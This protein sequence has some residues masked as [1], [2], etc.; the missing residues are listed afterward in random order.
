LLKQISPSSTAA[1]QDSA[2]SDPRQWLQNWAD[3]MRGRDP[4]AQASFYADTVDAYSGR[5]NVSNE[6]I[7]ANKR[8]GILNRRGLW[9]VRFDDISLHRQGDDDVSVNLVK[10][11][12][13]QVGPAQITEKFVRSRL[14]LR[15]IDGQWKIVSEQDL[16]LA[17]SP[18]ESDLP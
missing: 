16:P 5:R 6:Q 11:Y 15:L 13:A 8:A 10:H 9:T 4:I 7:L 14:L 1:Q 2:T 3:V 12:I 17:A 18:P